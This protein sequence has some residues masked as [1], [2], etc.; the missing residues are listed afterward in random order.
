MYGLDVLEP[1]T[2]ATTTGAVVKY[3]LG[4]VTVMLTGVLVDV[5]PVKL[6]EPTCG[7]KPTSALNA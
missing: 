4:G 6:K 5:G 2:V 7:T 1:D 3:P